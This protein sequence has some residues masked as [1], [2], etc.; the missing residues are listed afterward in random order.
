MA[1]E[2][3]GYRATLGYL[4]NEMGAPLTMTRKEAA[5]FLNVSLPFLDKLINKGIIK[6]PGGKIPLGS[7]A[8]Y[9]CG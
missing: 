8:S 2:K 6:A 5:I 4:M 3:D 7:I 9:L 1:R